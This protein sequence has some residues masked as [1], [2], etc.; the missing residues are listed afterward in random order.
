VYGEID[1]YVPVERS[2]EILQKTFHDK[3]NLLTVKLYTNTDHTIR[4]VP[5]KGEFEFPGYADGYI[6]DLLEWILK[7][8]K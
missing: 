6:H 7:Q 2:I 4:V 5:T 3:K 1:R 8:T